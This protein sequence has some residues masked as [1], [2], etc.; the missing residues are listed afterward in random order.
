MAFTDTNIPLVNKKVW[1]PMTPTPALSAAGACF[2]TDVFEQGNLGM[3]LVNATTH[4]MYHHDEDAWVQIPSGALAGT[5]GAGT[6][7]TRMRWS[8]TYTATAGS[9]TT[10]TTSTIL[11]GIAKGRTI[12]FLTGANAGKESIVTDVYVT[13]GTNTVITF[14]ALAGAVANTDTFIIDS[15]LY[16]VLNGGTL[17][18]GILKSYD[19]LTAI[20]TSLT[21]TG[22]PGT[23]N[24][25]AKLVAT[26]SNEAFATGTAT[27]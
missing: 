20:R 14:N 3:A 22:L 16:I 5:F 4:Y 11:S 9:T 19:P 6:C 27:A 18:A 21:Q 13:P 25:D 23:I 2:I 8:A 17:A 12:S 7:G 24:V 15:G 26:P 10:V 1:Q